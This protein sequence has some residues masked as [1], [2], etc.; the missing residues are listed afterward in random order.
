M[1]ELTEYEVLRAHQGDKDYAVGDTRKALAADV[2]H[3]VGTTLKE[4]PKPKAVK[5]K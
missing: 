2:A 1:A 4:K 3:L 5:A